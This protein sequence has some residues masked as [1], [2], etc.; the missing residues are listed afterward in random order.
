MQKT[1]K[2]QKITWNDIKDYGTEC[3][4]KYGFGQR[5]LERQ[6]RTHLDGANP[7]ERRQIY[8]TFYRNRK[9]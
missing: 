1:Q 9:V 3:N 4:K 7:S 8:E 5:E 6:V 2:Q